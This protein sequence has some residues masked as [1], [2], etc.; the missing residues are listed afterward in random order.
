MTSPIDNWAAADAY[1]R[2][3][4]RWSRGIASRFLTWLELPPSASWLEIGCG[5]GALTEVILKQADPSQILA[6]DPSEALIEIARQRIRDPRV[7]F[8]KA[9]PDT[10]AAG[11][12]PFQAAVS[13]LVLNFVENPDDHVRKLLKWVG[14]G[15]TIAAYVWDYSEG[16]EFLRI[17]W[18]VAV[19]FDPGAANADEGRRFP[20]CAPGPLGDLFIRCG[21]KEVDTVPLQIETAFRDFS[22]Y[23]EPFLGG[24][25]PAPS[26]VSRLS[27]ADKSKLRAL[28]RRRLEPEAGGPIT[29][30]AIAWGVRGIV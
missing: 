5:T 13:G 3:M 12:R 17:F 29:L 7:K 26:Y 18:D 15:G 11:R 14:E 19:A 30:S 23:W 22:D 27:D 4:G 20:I 25:G 1:E 6:T 10:L 16:M 28:L 9:D 2:F 24:I 21:L 8:G